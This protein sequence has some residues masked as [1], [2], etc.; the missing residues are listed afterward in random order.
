MKIESRTDKA[1][2]VSVLAWKYV[3]W[4]QIKIAMILAG[5]AQGVKYRADGQL[6][7]PAEGNLGSIYG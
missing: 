3:C 5:T 1:E 2:S 4:A 7:G 6:L